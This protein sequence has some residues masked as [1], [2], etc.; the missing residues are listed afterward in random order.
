MTGTVTLSIELELG[1]GIHDKQIYDHLSIKRS[2]ETQALGRLLDIA[3]HLKLPISFA[4]V[5]HLFHE[6]CSGVH[7][8]SYPP[9]WWI[10]DPGTNVESDPIFYAPD[11]ISSIQNSRIEHEIATHTYSH[12]LAKDASNEV[13]TAELSKVRELHDEFGLK[14]P[15]SIVMP[16]HQSPDY[17]TLTDN[18]INTIRKPVEGYEKSFSN[19]LSKPWWLLTRDHPVS[20]MQLNDGILETT[21]TP[22]PSLTSVTLPTGQSKPH[23][24]FRLIPN[25]IRQLFHRQY[26]VDAINQAAEESTHLH[27]WTHVYNF[28]NNDQWNPMSDGLKYLASQKDNGNVRVQRLQ[29][30][31]ISK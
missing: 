3:D 6:S 26:L 24:V 14:S 17:Q 15:R 22:H 8:G 18:D 9:E 28:A 21:V 19:P 11:L 30:L 31:Q 25:R 23:P 29:D 13:L 7:S 27:L 12:L 5:G 2:S 10:E 1:W 16:R 4:V 20:T